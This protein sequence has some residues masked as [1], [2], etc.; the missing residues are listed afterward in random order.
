[1]KKTKIL[2]ADDHIMMR[3]GLKLVLQTDSSFEIVGEADNGEEVVQLEKKLKPDVV[4]LDINMPKLNGIEA[5]RKIRSQNKGVKI[6]ILTMHESE[7]FIF[8]AISAGVNGYIFKMS[9]MEEFLRAVKTLA[10]GKDYFHENVANIL[11]SNYKRSTQGSKEE[12]EKLTLTKRE[13][14]ILKLIAQGKTSQEIAEILFISYFTVGKHRK[15]IMVKLD[16]K[17]T[18]ELVR[19]ALKEKIV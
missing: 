7:S 10:E 17:N 5:A 3:D 16:L 8:D 11:I 9:D 4:I 6:L 12:K 18:A 14:E 19:F 13:S 2:L 15:N 1:M